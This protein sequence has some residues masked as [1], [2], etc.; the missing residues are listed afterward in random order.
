MD[1]A[2]GE[3]T[4]THDTPDLKAHLYA[5]SPQGAFPS[6]RE[7]PDFQAEYIRWVNAYLDI[8][9]NAK[10]VLKDG[11]SVSI[12]GGDVPN[13]NADTGCFFER[14]IL[15]VAYMDADILEIDYLTINGETYP[16]E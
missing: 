10:L 14:S 7:N 4:W 15:P 6:F 16:L 3:V 5:I 13:F 2:T 11:S 12:G 8:W 9:N 1:L